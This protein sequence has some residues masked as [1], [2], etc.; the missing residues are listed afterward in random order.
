MRQHSGQLGF[1]QRVLDHASAMLAYWDTDLICRFANEGY[2]RWFGIAPADVVGMR[3]PDLLGETIFA[4]NQP[5]VRSV[6]AGRAQ[7]FERAIPGPD[8]IVRHSL[9]RYH[10]DI[11]DGVVVGFIAEVADVTPLKELELALMEQAA[12]KERALAILEKRDRALEAAQHLG[13]IGS[14]E[15]EVDADITTWSPE[16][17][18]LFGQDP[19]L[20]A[21][22]FSAHAV[23]YTAASWQQLRD[24]VTG[25]L[26]QGEPYRLQLEYVRAGQSNGWMDVRGEVERDHRGVIH[27]LRGT[28]QDV[29]AQYALLATVQEQAHRLTLALG[30]AEMGLWHWDPA[31][32]T[33]SCEDDRARAAFG[34]GARGQRMTL[35]VFCGTCLDPEHAA[36]FCAA[37]A[38]LAPAPGGAA[39]YFKGRTR[40]TDGAGARWI[41]CC[42]KL[43][44]SSDAGTHMIGT[45][46]D[47]TVRVSTGQSLLHAVLDLTETDARNRQFL[48]VLG[49]EMR[50]AIA[51]VAAGV[52]LLGMQPGPGQ[53]QKMQ[54]AMTRQVRHLERLVDDIYDLHRAQ[55]GDLTLRRSRISL[56]AVVD[57][58]GDMTLADMHKAHHH[59]SVHLPPEELTVDGDPVRLTQALVNLLCNAAKFT[60]P[61]GRIA[62]TL[63]CDEQHTATITVSDNGIG[64]A[65]DQ[66]DT[67]FGMYVKAAPTGSA[68]EDGLG[69][70][71]YLARR[72]VQLHGGTLTA[73]SAGIG[74]GSTMVIRL[75]LAG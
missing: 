5:F 4:L 32:G 34:I 52:A 10:P 37:L 74:C 64:L 69:I 19:A 36:A 8:G 13:K 6:L 56:N 14:W 44:T 7:V 67:I 73:T 35:D 17:Y 31:Q 50:N 3:M 72:L 66:L 57:G 43:A 11:V 40:A 42:G 41:E 65:P 12:M 53:L 33:V 23:L 70:G 18:R 25:A 51:P 58:A 28:V 62:L 38:A 20:I 71:L 39:F 29:T 47:I 55:G 26:T 21:P 2:R 68:P 48:S 9:A 27:A 16:L 30:A 22:R 24:A 46:A 45:V 15:W 49:H 75:P 63:A 54:G 60:A 61:Y 59:F 1:S